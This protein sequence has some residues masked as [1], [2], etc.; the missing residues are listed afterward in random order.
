MRMCCWEVLERNNGDFF[1]D[2]NATSVEFVFAEDEEAAAVPL[3]GRL[4]PVAGNK[5][6]HPSRGRLLR[7]LS[8]VK[9]AEDAPLFSRGLS[10][11]GNV[12]DV[13]DFESVIHGVNA[14]L[15]RAGSD[16][17]IVLDAS[18]ADLPLAVQRANTGRDGK[19]HTV[20][21]VFHDGRIHVVADEISSVEE[22]EAVIL[23]ELY[24]HRGLRA[25]F[26]DDIYN[27]L[28]RLARG[29]GARRMAQISRKQTVPEKMRAAAA[30]QRKGTRGAEGQRQAPAISD[31]QDRSSGVPAPTTP[32][33]IAPN[34]GAQLASLGKKITQGR[35]L[36]PVQFLRSLASALGAKWDDTGTTLY[37]RNTATGTNMTLR[38]ADHRGNARNFSDAGEFTGNFGIVVKLS[39]KRFHADARVEYREEVFFP[40]KLTAQSEAAIARGLADWVQTGR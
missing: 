22:L 9:Q 34:A 11:A 32:I 17:D 3:A 35:A 24:G 16:V 7:W 40:D 5:Q 10:S 6:R 36:R 38:L 33:Q 26:G 23:H 30:E 25:L 39:E 27:A 28:N 31:I 4:Q 19:Q 8:K 14:A 18:F 1:Y 15:I 29:L 2:A 13:S 37:F 20:Q 12:V 21:G